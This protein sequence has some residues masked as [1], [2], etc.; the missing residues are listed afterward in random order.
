MVTEPPLRFFFYGTLIGGVALGA[1]I[2]QALARLRDLGPAQVSG[3]LHAIPDPQGWY[4]ALVAGEGRASGRLYVAG[5]DFAGADLAALDAYEDC[6]SG[7]P[8]GSLYRREILANGA[9]AYLFNQPLPDGSRPIPEG[10][11][12]SWA[13]RNGMPIFTG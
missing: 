6:D 11:F 8:A 5:P 7:D 1:P 10:D 12:A 4:P 13:A 3:R 2:R 9:Q